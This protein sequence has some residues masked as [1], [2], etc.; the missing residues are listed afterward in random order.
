M[1]PEGISDEQW[2][3]YNKYFV[4]EHFLGLRLSD[5]LLA[6][7]KKK[8]FEE[9]AQNPDIQDRGENLSIKTVY[10][11]EVEAVLKNPDE[12]LDEP[13]LF[14]GVASDWDA[15]QNWSK[16]KFKTTYGKIVVPLIDQIPGIRK[17]KSK[18]NK[19][20]FEEYFNEVD[21]GNKIYLSFSRVLDHNPEL[22]EDLDIE[23]LRQ[24]KTGKTNGEQTFFFMGEE[25]TK[26]DVHNGFTQTMFIQVRG[27][28]KWIIWHPKERLF[29]NP[30]AGRHTHF[31]TRYLPNEPKNEDYP[32][33][34][35]A[36]KY[37][38][39]L[40]PGDVLWFPA[41]YWHYVENPMPNIGVAFKWVN[42]R[43]NFKISKLLTSM[44][45]G[46]TKPSLLESFVYN[47]IHKQDYVFHKE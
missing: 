17:S 46:A 10:T 39:L 43:D 14:K 32:L 19:I 16:E 44:V 31:Y 41:F 2:R 25:G 1:K 8:L 11:D 3:K 34:K 20:T 21:K 18:Y 33:A 30:V 23:W 47:L 9:I 38:I 13:V 15:V 6:A 37:E 28:K 7:K 22:L 42:L 24:F 35:F 40:E 4:M 5:K 27:Q 26:T 36:K 12:L 29:L 45:L